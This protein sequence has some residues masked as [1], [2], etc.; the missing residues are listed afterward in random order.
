MPWVRWTT[1]D[2]EPWQSGT[3][4]VGRWGEGVG[5]AYQKIGRRRAPAAPFAE[6]EADLA[7]WQSRGKQGVHRFRGGRQSPVVGASH[8]GLGCRALDTQIVVPC[9]QIWD[10]DDTISRTMGMDSAL[11]G[12]NFLCWDRSH[13]EN[14]N[15]GEIANKGDQ[16]PLHIGPVAHCQPHTLPETLQ[17]P[18]WLDRGVRW[19]RSHV[20]ETP[21]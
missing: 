10:G 8:R 21:P 1:H 17:R 14:S 7:L 19:T 3:W 16:N 2:D 4:V 6:V 11:A 9:E 13:L 12:P 15:L 5:D 18:H 20:V